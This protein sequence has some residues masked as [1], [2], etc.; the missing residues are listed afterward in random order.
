M[1][2]HH[3]L[4]GGVSQGRPVPVEVRPDMQTGAQQVHSRTIINH[5]A[6]VAVKVAVDVPASER[7][8]GN[9]NSMQMKSPVWWNN[10]LYAFSHNTRF[11]AGKAQA[12]LLAC[13][14]KI[15]TT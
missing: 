12:S 4:Q 14:S 1:F 6:Q 7:K 3:A 15:L 13:S 11:M 9:N 5:W 10:M 8:T 2:P